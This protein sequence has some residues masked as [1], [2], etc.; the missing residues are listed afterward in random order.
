MQTV[1]VEIWSLL[2]APAQFLAKLVV[3]AKEQEK[4]EEI[5]TI[6]LSMEKGEEK[7]K[8]EVLGV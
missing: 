2:L 8:G 3:G 4:V 1:K 6:N 7:G 5:V